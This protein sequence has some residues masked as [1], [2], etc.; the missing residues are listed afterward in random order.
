MAAK[1][2]KTKLAY[3]NQSTYGASNAWTDIATITDITPPEIAAE[4]IDVSHMESPNEFKE[5]Q[6]GWAESGE[7]SCTVQFAKAQNQQLYSLFRV[8]KGYR[9]MFNDAPSPSGSTL[10]LDGYISKFGNEVDRA[11]IVTAKITIKITGETLFTPG[12]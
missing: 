2:S 1:G 10:K 3:G 7:L 12:T 4:D 5:W 9:M 11:G 6:P 8:P